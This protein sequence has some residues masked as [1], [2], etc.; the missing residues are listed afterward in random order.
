M[1]AEPMSFLNGFFG[2]LK[3]RMRNATAQDLGLPIAFA[4]ALSASVSAASHRRMRAKAEDEASRLREQL[5]EEQ[6]HSAA[7]S[8]R[9]AKVHACAHNASV[10]G[11]LRQGD[12][13]QAASTDCS[14]RN[15]RSAA[16]MSCS[17]YNRDS[18]WASLL[19]RLRGSGAQSIDQ[20][21]PERPNIIL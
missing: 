12:V 14:S 2:E 21:K 10:L 13:L 7:L 11:I 20:K 9:L 8:Q 17:H 15:D 16:D 1:Q 5:Q 3:Q 6:E 4:L 18:L 19:Q